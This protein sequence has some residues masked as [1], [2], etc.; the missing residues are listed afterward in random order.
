MVLVDGISQRIGA[1]EFFRMLP[2]IVEGAAEKNADAEID[3]DEI[4]GDQLVVHN[5]ARRHVHGAAPFRHFF[6]G[7]IA[8]SRVIERAP[9]TQE[10]AAS[11]DLFVPGQCLI[12]EVEE[13]VV[14]R[15]DLLHEFNVLHEAHEIIGK[16]LDGW[17]RAYAAWIKRGRMNVP[18]FH[19][20][21][22]FT[23]HAA[24]LQ[25]FAIEGTGEGI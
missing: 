8:D 2:A 1:D 10:N 16:E 12:E 19:E 7:V 23:R 20:A 9:T 25:R 24:H 4:G 13:V 22:H 18:A 21:E 6:V 17:D 15:H 11:A 3:V 5:N 14:E